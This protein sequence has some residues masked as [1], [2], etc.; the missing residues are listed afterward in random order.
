MKATDAQGTVDNL[1]KSEFA[2][3]LRMMSSNVRKLKREDIYCYERFIENQEAS[4]CEVNGDRKLIIGSYNYLGLSHHPKVIEST[5]H[6]TSRFGVGAHGSR[7]TVGTTDSHRRLEREISEWNETDDTMVVSSGLRGC[8]KSCFDGEVE[9]IAN[10]Q[11][12]RSRRIY[13]DSSMQ[14]DEVP[15]A[16]QPTVA[17]IELLRQALS[18]N[19]ATIQALTQ[20]GD[21]VFF[22]TVNHAS[23]HD[24]CKL[25]EAT[26]VE[27]SHHD[28]D[29]LDDK[30]DLHAGD[31]IKFIVVDSVFSMDGDIVDLPRLCS[32][33]EKHDAIL[34]VDE[35][36]SI[37]VLG[38][39]G[40]GVTSHF[41][42]S[43]DS[44]DVRIG[45]LSKALPGIGGFVSGSSELIES[46]KATSHAFIFSGAVP[47]GVIEGARTSLGIL[48][49]DAQIIETLH[50]NRVYMSERLRAAGFDLGKWG[51][52]TPIIPVM[53]TSSRIACN[54]AKQCFEKGLLVVPAI[55]PV[56]AIDA[57]RLRMTVTA[58][59]TKEDIDFAVNVLIECAD[60]C[61]LPRGGSNG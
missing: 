42:M 8:L 55:F 22:D 54:M 61:G 14:S 56:V 27:F 48:R 4:Y 12:R 60:E 5:N 2:R 35:A 23:L 45:V 57:A 47:I 17:Q 10:R 24:G 26:L 3:R 41:Q 40:S 9:R 50:E 32:L 16:M 51:G 13:L 21:T 15:F 59:L 39:A 43:P 58:A 49:D 29:A 19:I 31:G 30:L 28:L 52:S 44:I 1:D 46:L 37:G 18:A 11:G 6:A 38:N 36:H 53:C 34:I 33:C 20:K 7:I 25:S